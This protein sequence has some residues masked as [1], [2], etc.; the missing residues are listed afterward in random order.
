MIVSSVWALPSHLKK[1]TF[2]IQKLKIRDRGANMFRYN[3]W[4]TFN[5]HACYDIGRAD[6]K[7]I[8]NRKLDC[9]LK[10]CIYENVYFYR[11]AVW[12]TYWF[13]QKNITKKRM[14]VFSGC[15][16][17]FC[18]NAELMSNAKSLCKMC[19]LGYHVQLLYLIV[20]MNSC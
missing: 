12:K 5:A 11:D 1:V 14:I 18:R 16:L 13:K 4:I 2:W 7:W 19:F 10:I 20:S 17:I 15:Q 8:Q 9:W 3:W 6:S